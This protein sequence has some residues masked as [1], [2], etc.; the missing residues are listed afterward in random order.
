MREDRWKQYGGSKLV[1]DD[2]LEHTDDR[3]RTRHALEQLSEFLGRATQEGRAALHSLRASTTETNDL[4]AAFR[5]ALEDCRRGMSMETGFSVTG[6][7]REM[8][9]VVRDEVYR[10]GYEAIHNACVHSAGSRVN[11]TLAYGQDLSLGIYD[12]GVGIDSA[13]AEAGRNGHFGL[14]GM[15]ERA[16]RI[17]ARLTM[18][19][20]ANSGTDVKLIVPGS[21]VFRKPQA[22]A[23]TGSRPS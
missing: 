18:V 8:H 2:A 7:V 1:A 14:Q 6:E 15:R 12:N 5:R 9:P 19:S 11:V 21:I 23:S 3:D 22:T 17:G 20:S 13:I 10:I 4:A 16:A